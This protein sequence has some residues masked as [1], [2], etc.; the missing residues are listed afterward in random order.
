MFTAVVQQ[1]PDDASAYFN[2]GV[3]CEQLGRL[4]EAIDAYERAIKYNPNHTGA[5]FNLALTYLKKN[6]KGAALEQ[7][8]VLR[9][10][11]PE[12]AQKLLGNI[13]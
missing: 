3:A 5:R 10:L 2:L 13:K 9:R 6:E 12:L 1:Q 11:N 4:E 8:E 7:Y